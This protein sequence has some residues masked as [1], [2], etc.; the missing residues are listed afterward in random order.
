MKERFEGTGRPLLVETLKKQDFVGHDNGLAEELAGK[1][2][3][4]ELAQGES[5]IVQGHESTD[6][7]LLLAGSV[8]I[9]VNG[10]QI[11]TRHAGEHVG[12]MAAI[13]P[14]E[15]RSASVVALQT[16]VALKLDG[17]TF[18]AI[19]ENHPR[20]WKPVAQTIAR[21]LFERNRHIPKPNAAPKLFI[22]SST[23]ALAIAE[24]IRT[25]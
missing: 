6:V 13:N 16:V 24:S 17:P 12:E 9:V 21:R 15:T 20:I 10:N 18:H 22:I 23:E 1:G 25:Q 19:G 4:V 5:L 7:F 3:L 14:E 8:A 2:S 11:G